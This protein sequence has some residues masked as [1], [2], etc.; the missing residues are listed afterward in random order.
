[1]LLKFTALIT[2]A[3]SALAQVTFQNS[4]GTRLRIDNGTYGPELEEV[5]YCK[6]LASVLDRSI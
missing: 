6:I 3:A 4:S 2:C 1:M 5:H